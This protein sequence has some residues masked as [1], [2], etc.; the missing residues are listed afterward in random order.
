MS[1]EELLGLGQAKHDFSSDSKVSVSTLDTIHESPVSIY[2]SG[3]VSLWRE[4]TF[5]IDHHCSNDPFVALDSLEGFLHLC[6]QEMRA[7]INQKGLCETSTLQRTTR[8][9]PSPPFL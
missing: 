2:A 4:V 5:C 1:D 8:K 9:L 6:L 7:T 3:P